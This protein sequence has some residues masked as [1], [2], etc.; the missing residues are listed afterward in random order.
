MGMFKK[1]SIKMK[2]PSKTKKGISIFKSRHDPKFGRFTK[3]D[4]TPSFV[5]SESR[6]ESKAVT[7]GR[8]MSDKNTFHPLEDV[9]LPEAFV[10]TK[11]VG[12]NVAVPI[13]R[14]KRR[15]KFRVWRR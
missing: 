13:W 3:F 2:I 12:H 6:L 8:Y 1:S 10:G 15:V 14:A 11:K 7:K 5:K 4:K 9:F